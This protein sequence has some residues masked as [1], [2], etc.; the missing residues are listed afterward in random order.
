MNRLDSRV[1]LCLRFAV[2]LAVGLAAVALGKPTLASERPNVLL[3]VVDDLRC[4]LGCYGDASVK[5]PN[6][7]RLAARGVRFDRA[8][9]QYPMCNPSR[10]SFLTGMRPDTLRIL[11][12]ATPLRKTRPEAVTLPQLFREA[13]YF[14]AGIGKIFHVGIGPDGKAAAFQEAKSWDE[15]RNYEP[16]PTGRRGEGRS[17]TEDRLAWCRWLSADGGDEDQPDGQTAAEAVRLIEAHRDGPFFLGVGFHKPHDPFIAPQAYFDMYPPES[18][19]I[20]RDPADRTPDVPLAT[21]RGANLESFKKFTDRERREFRRAYH[22]GISFTDAQV[23]KVLNTL[24]RLKLWDNTIVAFLGDHGYHLGEHGWWNKVTVFELSARPP[25]IVWAPGMKG[26]G[27]A[28]AG[29]VEFVDILP[30]IADLCGLKTPASVEGTSF[31]P[32]LDDPSRPGKRAA[33]TQVTRGKTMGRSVRSERWRYTEWGG[34]KDGVE[35][36][37][38]DNDPLE[39]HNL[40]ADPRR[41]PTVAEMKALLRAGNR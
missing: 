3:I 14:T 39:Y 10:N 23:G 6:V 1:A 15:C 40:A 33:Y 38:H 21:P 12:N 35:L 2:C 5:S 11:D 7:D 9:C 30:T 32:L 29:M 20:A 16:T 13:G 19:P 24:D 34:G 4:S 31:R 17:L 41:A 25:L 26:M 36:Y 27:H 37:D 8:Y 28:T 18:I 22:A